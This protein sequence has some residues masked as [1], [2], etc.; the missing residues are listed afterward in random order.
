MTTGTAAISALSGDVSASGNGTVTATVTAVGGST[1]GNVHA[2]T[3][4]ANASTDTNTAS[5]IVRRNGVGGFSAGTVSA[6]SARLRDGTTNYVELKAPAVV[7][8]YSITLPDTVGS[9]GQIL[10]ATDAAGTLGWANPNAGSKWTNNGPD[11]YFNTGSVG[12]GTTSP[13]ASALLDLASTSK[14]VLLPRMT[15]SERDTIATPANGLQIYNTSTNALNFYDGSTWQALG[16][17]G[18]GVQS[19]GGQTGGT[20]TFAAGSAGTSPAIT[21]AGNVHTLNVPFANAVGVTRGTISKTEYDFFNSK[22]TSPLTTKGD[23]ITRGDATHVRLPAGSD[24]QVLRVNSATASGL[25]WAAGNAGTVTNVTSSN[26]YLT[27]ATGTT[28]P[29][30]TANVG[31]VANTLAA[32]DDSRITGALQ[33]SAYATDVTDAALCTAAQMP[34][35]NSVT[36]RW[37]CAS[38]SG[39][40]AS[41]ISSGTIAT[42]R[43]GSGTADGTSFLRGDGTWAAVGGGLPATSGTAAAPGYAFNGDTNTGMFGAAADQIGFSTGGSERIRVDASGNVGIGTANP[44]SR[45][46][47]FN[48]AASNFIAMQTNGGYLY[49]FRSSNGGDFI[50][51]DSTNSVDILNINPFAAG[52]RSFNILNSNVGVGTSAPERRFHVAG[53]RTLLQS[54]GELYTLGIGR[55]DSAGA[56]WLGSTNSANPDFLI[57]NSLGTERMRVTDAG[58]VGIGTTTPLDLLAING[59]AAGTDGAQGLS[60]LYNATNWPRIRGGIF[61]GGNSSGPGGVGGLQIIAQGAHMSSA[62]SGNIHFLTP[63]GDS[64]N[65]TTDAPVNTRMTILQNGNVGIG[66][67]I[68][69][70]RLVVTNNTSTLPA[71]PTN[72]VASFTNSNGVSSRVLISNYGGGGSVLTLRSANGTASAPSAIL[73]GQQIGVMNFIGYGGTAFSSG[74]RA[75]IVGYAAEN[76]TD[77]AQGSSMSILTTPVGEI[78]AQERMKIDHSGNVGI[79]VASPAAKLDVAGEVKFGNTSSTCNA[80]N[81][82]QQRYNSTSKAMEFCNG[83]AWTAYGSG[84]GGS[85]TGCPAGTTLI[86]SSNTYGNSAFCIETNARASAVHFNAAVNCASARRGLCTPGQIYRAHDAGGTSLT[87]GTPEW[88]STSIG[89]GGT[90]YF[91][92]PYP[93]GAA[94][95]GTQTNSFQ[96]RCC[97]Q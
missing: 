67:T 66:T 12:V 79:G 13:N 19:L 71:D 44:S 45:L 31:M 23:L 39:L 58:N 32:G 27:V 78:G 96:Y 48:S 69:S 24:G 75:S 85:L 36:D 72:T 38:I 73:G 81:E 62:G 56:I 11:I 92:A 42:A 82:G 9:S 10:V 97:L 61:H 25:E 64:A 30:I 4:L 83:T 6:S 21:S 76:W 8:S 16:V 26:S 51:R 86:P 18:S 28:T 94:V 54:D 89:T 3:V 84:S 87:V 22:L 57:S 40:P 60:V 50:L 34:Y 41:A 7:S 37:M 93:E 14:G 95:W 77:S 49:N 70:V 33:A 74:A 55:I 20:Q 59:A 29:A 53:G 80:A 63:T 68:P 88:S 47:V 35:W 17:A 1:A 43:L 52:G 2:A 91:Q 46:H 90:Q 65:G 15:T 5:T